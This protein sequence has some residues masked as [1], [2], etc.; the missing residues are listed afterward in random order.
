MLHLGKNHCEKNDCGTRINRLLIQKFK[1]C[2][3]YQEI[4][5]LIL[6]DSYFIN[7]GNKCDVT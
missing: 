6:S 7:K 1:K 5:E 4:R 2:L 3:K